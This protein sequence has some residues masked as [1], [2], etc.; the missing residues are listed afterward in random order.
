MG[1][2]TCRDPSVR[3][4]VS[5]R[6]PGTLCCRNSAKYQN[7]PLRYATTSK[8]SASA[9][10]PGAHRVPLEVDAGLR[11]YLDKWTMSNWTSG[12][13]SRCESGP[14]PTRRI[15]CSLPGKGT[16]E[17]LVLYCINVTQDINWW[18]EIVRIVLLVRLD[19]LGDYQLLKEYCAPW[20]WPYCRM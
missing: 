12:F 14:P 1:R 2:S 18:R 10:G 15:C 19:K 4:F 20:G 16:L 3:R 13:A 6:S 8:L 11:K 7:V 5:T 9:R 17:V